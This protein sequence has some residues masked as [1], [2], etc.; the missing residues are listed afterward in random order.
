MKKNRT[1]RIIFIIADTLRAQ[2]VG[3]YG[4]NPSP[5]PNID[6]LGKTGIV[7]DNAYTTITKTDP[8]ITTI[9]TGRYPLSNG[10]INHGPEITRKEEKNLSALTFLAEILKKHGYKTFAVDW[11]SRWHKRGYG[12]YSGKLTKD[13][14]PSFPLMGL[15]FPLILRILDKISVK[16]LKREIFLRFYY[17][18]F[19]NPKIPYDPAD[20]VINKAI[21]ILEKN[22]NEN[23]FVYLHLWDA[24]APHTRPKGLYSYLFDTAADTYNAEIKFLDTE[25]GRLIDQLKKTNQLRNTLIVL[26]SDHG[27]NLYEHDTPFN[28]EGLYE[29]VVKVPLIISH[30]L[31]PVGTISD[32]VQH[33]DIFPTILDFL[34]ISGPDDIDGKSLLP[35]IRGGKKSKRRSV[36]FED[37][38]YRKL[39]IPRNTRRIGIR[40]GEYKFIKTLI[41]EKKDIYAIMPREDLKITKE[42]LFNL[43]KD[44]FEKDNLVQKKQFL[45]NKLRQEMFTKVLELNMKR[46][47]KNNPDL[48][49]K[50]RKSMAVIKKSTQR[51]KEKDVAVA[52]TG[53]KDSTVLLHLIRI[54][55]SGKVPFRVVFNDSTMEFNEIYKFVEKM[56]QL[57]GINLITIKHSALELKGFHKT[58]DRDKQKELSRIMKITAINSALKKYKIKA[59]M[60]GIRWDEHESRSKEKFFSPRPDH[61]RI[62]PIL[63]FTEKDIW[64]Y[65]RHFGVPY[66][67][68]YAKGY[69]SLGEKPFTKKAKPGE[70]ERSGREK[71]KEQ[72]MGRLRRMGYW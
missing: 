20:V 27:E 2:N 13:C 71:D 4:A 26:T 34:K 16:Y 53:G 8:A 9:M 58:K 50:V 17:S 15:P 10:L 38:T 46:L 70:S 37:L 40:I 65:T 36:Y 56:R 7:F 19:T 45:S 3:L 25:I 55:F 72:L 32:S 44:P 1:K 41:G 66:V 57:W 67:D 30:G 59:F 29:D 18:L 43:E 68:L 48:F 22:K 31:L 64:E 6:A 5:T 24:H 42:T 21:K 60:A 35:L 63:D 61:M 39:E 49:S 47:Q 28:H 23:I 54:T 51:F 33:I 14:D 12:Y 11:L 52:W 69:R 62:H